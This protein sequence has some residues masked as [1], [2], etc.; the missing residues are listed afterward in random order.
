MIGASVLGAW[1]VADEAKIIH[2]INVDWFFDRAAVL[3]RIDNATK[4]S[5]NRAGKIVRDQ[6]RK[7]IRRMG[8]LRKR[9]PEG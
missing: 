8:N 2:R 1:P 3:A 4:I 5:L 9:R 7:G 6:T